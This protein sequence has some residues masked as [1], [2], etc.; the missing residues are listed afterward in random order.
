MPL[1]YVVQRHHKQLAKGTIGPGKIVADLTLGTWVMLLSRSGN[2]SLGRV[3]D[4]ETNLW[5]PALR[6][7]SRPDPSR[8]PAGSV[9]QHETRSMGEHP[10]SGDFGTGLL[11]TSRS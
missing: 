6:F 4:Y 7:G 10:T 8:Q 5:R 11:T 2:S 9:G 3:I 1:A